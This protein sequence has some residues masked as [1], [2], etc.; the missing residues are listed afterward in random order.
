MLTGVVGEGGTYAL[1]Q[2]LY[3]PRHDDVDDDRTL[4][5][6][7]LR[8]QGSDSSSKLSPRYWWPLLVMAS[9]FSSRQMVSMADIAL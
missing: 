2:G 4:T 9:S 1:F 5:G 8:R 3:P 7:S 6:D